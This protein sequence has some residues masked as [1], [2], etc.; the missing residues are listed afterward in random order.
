MI[1][2]PTNNAHLINFQLSSDA[3]IL[4]VFVIP[5]FFLHFYPRY[6]L[7]RILPCLTSTDFTK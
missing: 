5:T 2:N 6:L 1:V 3:E 7:D 4:L